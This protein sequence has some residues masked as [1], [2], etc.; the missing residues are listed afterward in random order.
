MLPLQ[1]ETDASV[2]TIGVAPIEKEGDV[3]HP[4]AYLSKAF[5]GVELNW[6]IGNKE[7]YA[8]VY[9]FTSWWHWLL[10][11]KYEVKV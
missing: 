10:P 9:I 11:T 3:W 8:V 2:F 7:I 4:T 6:P 5:L 1:V